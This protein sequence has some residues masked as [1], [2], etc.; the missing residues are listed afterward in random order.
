MTYKKNLFTYLLGFI[1]FQQAIT[2]LISGA[3]LYSPLIVDGDPSLSLLNLADHYNQVHLG[4]FLD[5]LTSIG[6]IVLGTCMYHIGKKVQPFLA[7]LALAFY[8]FEAGLLTLSKFIQY[9]LVEMAQASPDLSVGSVPLI[10]DVLIRL[11]QFIYNI[12]ILPFGIG[13]IL[14]YYLLY[15]GKFLPTWLSLWG[16]LTTPLILIGVTLSTYGF[17]IPF[18]VLLPYVPFEFF[19]GI[20][21]F[22]KGLK[23]E[24]GPQGS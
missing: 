11:Y 13:A 3:V 1:F 6:I 10:G 21:I 8:I 7:Q 22:I 19:T 17:E 14:F 20:F 5:I 18:V 9:V 2:S 12:H 24:S 15:K 4:I 23:L 16:L